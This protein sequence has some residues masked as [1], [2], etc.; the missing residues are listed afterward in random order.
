MGHGIGTLSTL[1]IAD[2]LRMPATVQGVPEV[3]TGEWELGRR[4]RWLHVT[5]LADTQGLLQGGELILTTGIALPQSQTELARYIDALADQGVV[6]LVLELGRRFAAPPPAMVRACER[7]DLPLVVLRREVQFVMMTEAAHSAIIGGQRQLLQVT[8]AA[9]ER[10]TELSLADASVDELIAATGDLADGQIIFSNLLHQVIALDARDAPAEQLLG[11]WRRMAFSM[12]PGFG[13]VLDETEGSVTTPVEVHGQQR[14]RLTLFAATAPTAAQVMV[15]ERAAAALTIRLLLETD[16]VLVANARRTVLSDIISGRYSS[17]DAMH[18]RTLALGHPTRN[19]RLVPMV[20][21]SDRPDLAEIVRNALV[22]TNLDAISARL[23]DDRFGVLLL[24]ANQLERHVEPFAARVHELCQRTPGRRPTL[25]MGGEVT[26]IA[27]V[28]RSFAEAIEVGQAARAGERLTRPRTCYSIHD[29]QLRGLLYTMRNDPRLQAFVG[30]T[31]GPLL[32]RDTRDG[33]DWVRTVAV[34][35]KFRGNK[36]L[37][38]QELGISRPTLYERL[39]RIQRLLQVDLDD[40]E[41]ST[42]LYA[43][44]MVVEALPRADRTGD[45]GGL[46]ADRAT[47]SPPVD[48]LSARRRTA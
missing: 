11:R 47:P 33:G 45:P 5:E 2:F 18:A 9:H 28:R 24:R 39:A 14:G 27:E 25:A 15:V 41:S 21:I 20:V 44:I 40:P 42:S 1:T 35:F 13:T 12:S 36:S 29:I 37:A 32:V 46:G 31:L 38:A 22:H 8:A 6:G 23:D 43:A 48:S 17:A 4:I 10:F 34:Y 19:R 7:R 26:D 3:V 16:D 30:R